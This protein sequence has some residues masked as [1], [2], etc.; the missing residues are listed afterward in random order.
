MY[1]NYQELQFK[2]PNSLIK[3]ERVD[4][5]SPTNIRVRISKLNEIIRDELNMTH[6]YAGKRITDYSIS[7][8]GLYSRIKQLEDS[9]DVKF[10]FQ[11]IDYFN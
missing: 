3:S 11:N 5:L 7:A 1:K 10:E 8:S 6:K 9:Q 4:K 2:N